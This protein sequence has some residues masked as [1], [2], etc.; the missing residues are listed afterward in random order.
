MDCSTSV[1]V[2]ATA[3]ATATDA[4]KLAFGIE[5][6]HWVEG[7]GK[8]NFDALENLADRLYFASGGKDSRASYV[9]ACKH[10]LSLPSL[11]AT[12]LC[13]TLR[14]CNDYMEFPL[15]DDANDMCIELF[16]CSLMDLPLSE[17]DDRIL[18]IY[19]AN[20]AAFEKSEAYRRQ[21]MIEA[22]QTTPALV[23]DYIQRFHPGHDLSNL[24][25]MIEAAWINK[26][27]CRLY[28]STPVRTANG[29]DYTD[30]DDPDTMPLL[31]V[32]VPGTRTI[33]DIPGLTKI[34]ADVVSFAQSTKLTHI[35]MYF[36]EQPGT[37]IK[38][39]R[40]VRWYSIHSS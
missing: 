38:G 2:T 33:D 25:F 1:A 39:S 22:N 6:A 40:L 35:P 28:R 24:P 9:L 37:E 16:G 36:M 8:V 32:D 5:W 7:I 17:L 11:A 13:T 10:A 29:F 15:I 3:T 20:L 27:H 18:R 30:M 12:H 4:L 26:H 21:Q 14:T 31:T 34:I 23:R 19:Q